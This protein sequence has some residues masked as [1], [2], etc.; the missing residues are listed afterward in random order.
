MSRSFNLI[1]LDLFQCGIGTLVIK[2]V[3]FGLL[4]KQVP[5]FHEG[6]Q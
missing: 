2:I 5:E 1:F 3:C 6:L 4:E